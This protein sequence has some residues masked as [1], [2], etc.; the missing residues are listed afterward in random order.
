MSYSAFRL[1]DIEPQLGLTIKESSTL[2]TDVQV[3]PVSAA[4][5]ETLDYNLP[6]ALEISTEKAR[7]EMILVPILIELK[8]IFNS[9]ISL[10][11]GREFNIDPEQGLV[12]FCDFL[13]SQ[14]ASQLIIKAPVVVIVEAKNDNIQ[15]GLGQ[16][17]AVM[18]AAQIFN[19]R[20]GNGVKEV[21]GSVTTGTNWKFLQLLDQ[22]VEVDVREYFLNDLS[23]ILGVLKKFISVEN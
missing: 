8:K 15:S 6:L 18:Y 10:F 17:I 7:S 1:D 4:L 5:Q 12:G 2:F 19:Q 22:V 23:L 13:I 20:Q 3:Q 9:K 16:C 14:S 11:S 21:Y